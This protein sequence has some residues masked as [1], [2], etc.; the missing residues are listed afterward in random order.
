MKESAPRRRRTWRGRRTGSP[1]PRHVSSA[2][3]TGYSLCAGSATPAFWRSSMISLIRSTVSSD[4]RRISQCVSLITPHRRGGDHVGVARLAR[5]QTH[6]ADQVPLLERG[7]L[8][9]ALDDVGGALLDR[10]QLG[11]VVALL[12]QD[13]ALGDARLGR[14]GGQALGLLVGPR[15]ENSGIAFSRF[16]SMVAPR[17]RCHRGGRPAPSEIAA[18]VARSAA[19]TT[20]SGGRRCENPCVINPTQPPT[21]PTRPGA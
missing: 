1:L 19:G 21:T 5:E 2:I 3:E 12:H 8:L 10:D 9:A 7:D 11:R 20:L 14:E 13:L 18:R 15:W 4:I 17:L 6:L 16:G